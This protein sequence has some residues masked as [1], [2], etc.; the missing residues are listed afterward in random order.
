MKKNYLSVF[1]RFVPLEAA[2]YCLTLYHH[3]GFE[4]KIKKSRRTKFGDY[5]FEPTQ[6]KHVIT[7]NNDLNHYAFL[8]TYLHEVAHLLTY[9][10]HKNEVKPHGQEWKNAFKMVSLP[11][12]NTQVFPELLLKKL[13]HYLRSPKA[14]SCSDPNLHALLKQY[15]IPDDTCLLKTLKVGDQFLFNNS[16]YKFLEFKRTR[17]LCLRITSGKKYLISQITSVKKISPSNG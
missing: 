9:K 6:Q 13:A 15:D 7:I 12:L 14:S 2:Q 8:I 5:R 17:I 11:V 1:E 4:F 16:S 3:Y 10:K